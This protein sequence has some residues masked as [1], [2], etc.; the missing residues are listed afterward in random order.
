MLRKYLLIRLLI[1][2]WPQEA[3]LRSIRPG[4]RPSA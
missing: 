1:D 3:P 4:L 2:C